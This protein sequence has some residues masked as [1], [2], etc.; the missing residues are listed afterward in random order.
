MVDAQFPRTRGTKMD[1]Q[2]V[3]F[4]EE[5]SSLAGASR[6]G[7]VEGSSPG[8]LQ[9]SRA[10]DG[11][12]GREPSSVSLE[13]LAEKVGTLGLQRRKRNRCGAA[14][15]G[16]GRARLAVAS[17][18]APRPPGSEPHQQETPSTAGPG[19]PMVAAVHDMDAPGPLAVR[20]EECLGGPGKRQWSSG[21]TPVGR[22]VKRPKQTGQPSYARVAREG[23]R[24]AIVC[25]G[26]PGTQ[27]P[28]DNFVTIQ[29]AVGRPVDELPEEG[30]TPGLADSYWAKGAAIMVCQDQETCD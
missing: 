25:E 11:A 7:P 3:T 22:H 14:R 13:G 29:K 19:E 2:N 6:Q 10:S 27:V 16:A 21:G 1:A 5:K 20:D 18:Q 26:Y 4:Q 12:T 23:F 15:R 30:F 24:V 9:C 17:G 28:K 8:E